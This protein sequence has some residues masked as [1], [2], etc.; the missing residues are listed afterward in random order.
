VSLSALQS[1]AS[2]SFLS[3]MIV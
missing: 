3:S 2:A 1:I